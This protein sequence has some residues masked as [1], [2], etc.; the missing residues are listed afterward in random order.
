MER[1]NFFFVQKKETMEGE[2]LLLLDFV[3][4]LVGMSGCVFI[5][6]YQTTGVFICIILQS[7]I[8]LEFYF[9]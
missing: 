3:V 1:S 4:F 6:P 5:C 8:D 7:I 2:G 9:Y